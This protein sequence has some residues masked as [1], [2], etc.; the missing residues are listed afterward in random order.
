MRTGAPQ[1]FLFHQY[2]RDWGFSVALFSWSLWYFPCFGVSEVRLRMTRVFPGGLEFDTHICIVSSRHSWLITVVNSTLAARLCLTPHCG[3]LTFEPLSEC[4]CL[5]AVF[6]FGP[7]STLFLLVPPLCW[8]LHALQ[9]PAYAPL[10]PATLLL[11][12]HEPNLRKNLVYQPGTPHHHH[13][14]RH[15]ASQP[16]RFSVF[17][18][19]SWPLVTPLLTAPSSSCL[20]E[21]PLDCTSFINC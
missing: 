16:I 1:V 8:R 18:G 3:S 19:V 20:N 15:S 6:V 9:P 7:D 5:F 13:H 12:P 11:R 21:L 4:F 10:P 2:C 17:P 14:H